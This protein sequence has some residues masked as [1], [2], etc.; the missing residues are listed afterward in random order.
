MLW[1]FQE[2][3]S[4]LLFHWI[5]EVTMEFSYTG[6]TPVCYVPFNVTKLVSPPVIQSSSALCCCGTF[7]IEDMGRLLLHFDIAGAA[8]EQCFLMRCMMKV[9]GAGGVNSQ[10]IRLQ[11]LYY[12]STTAVLNRPYDMI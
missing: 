2:Q 3:T 11:A 5:I 1:Q 7:D 10:L 6:V 4:L 8:E 12:Y 9:S